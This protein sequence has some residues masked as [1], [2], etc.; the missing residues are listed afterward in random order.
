MREMCGKFDFR[1][2]AEYTVSDIQ[3]TVSG[4]QLTAAYQNSSHISTGTTLHLA[5]DLVLQYG[6]NATSYQILNPGIEH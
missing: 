4:E 6:W 1:C 5:L 3:M 2:L